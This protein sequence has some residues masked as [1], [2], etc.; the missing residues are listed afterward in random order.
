MIALLPELSSVRLRETESELVVEVDVPA[1][2][3]LPQLAALLRDGVLT[4]TVPRTQP[5][6]TD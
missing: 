2:V 3:E 1:D 5:A 4:I 6:R